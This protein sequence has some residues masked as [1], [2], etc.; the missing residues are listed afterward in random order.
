MALG[1]AGGLSKE[2]CSYA[3]AEAH[4]LVRGWREVSWV[5]WVHWR[6]AHRR[7]RLVDKPDVQTCALS[8]LRL[9]SVDPVSLL[10]RPVPCPSFVLCSS[11]SGLVPTLSLVEE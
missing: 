3:G 11:H 4:L 7:L 10:S 6:T 2:L 1:Q 5:G 8:Q 9:F